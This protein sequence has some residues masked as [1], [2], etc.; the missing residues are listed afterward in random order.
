MTCWTGRIGSSKT[1][2]R[3]T[4]FH[5]KRASFCQDRLGTNI[6]GKVEKKE[7]RF[8]RFL[9]SRKLEPLGMIALGAD[10][11]GLLLVFCDDTVL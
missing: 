1:P 2:F 11:Q 7:W 4:T 3:P 6:L 5:T 9:E 8:R 10:K